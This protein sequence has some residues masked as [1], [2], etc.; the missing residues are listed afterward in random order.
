[1]A[2]N[3]T[4]QNSNFAIFYDRI[5]LAATAVEEVTRA[6]RLSLAHFAHFID[7]SSSAQAVADATAAA[8]YFLSVFLF[9]ASSTCK[10]GASPSRFCFLHSSFAFIENESPVSGD[11]EESAH[12]LQVQLCDR[13]ACKRG[14]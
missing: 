11:V 7:R 3:G 1:M 6:R 14:S 13:Y 9:A 5:G 2:K 12:S 8:A 4:F 10:F